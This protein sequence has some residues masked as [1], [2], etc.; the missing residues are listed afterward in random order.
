MLPFSC[1]LT[2]TGVGLLSYLDHELLDHA[3]E[4]VAVV[5]PVPRVHAEVLHRLG[6]LLREQLQANVK[7]NNKQKYKTLKSKKFNSLSSTWTW[8][9]PTE[10]WRVACS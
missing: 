9:S 1:S 5:V 2:T 4:D 3:V 7:V 10:V 6:A 8:M